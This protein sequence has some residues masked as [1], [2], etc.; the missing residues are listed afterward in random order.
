MVY[1]HRRVR[2]LHDG[3]SSHGRPPFG[4]FATD[5]LTIRRCFSTEW[6]AAI[7]L[8]QYAPLLNGF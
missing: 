4:S 5:I 1:P 6:Y 2:F 8:M 3:V 7:R